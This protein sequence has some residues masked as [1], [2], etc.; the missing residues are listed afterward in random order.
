MQDRLA[1]NG[2]PIVCS[3]GAQFNGA[4]F[5]ADCRVSIGHAG[6]ID[7]DVSLGQPPAAQYSKADPKRSSSDAPVSDQHGRRHLSSAAHAGP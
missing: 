1:V 6:V 7:T 5:P 4:A 2:R 3:C